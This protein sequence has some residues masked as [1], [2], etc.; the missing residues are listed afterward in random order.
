M[1][2]LEAIEQT[3]RTVYRETYEDF[4][5]WERDE[6]LLQHILRSLRRTK[7]APRQQWTDVASE[8]QESFLNRQE[9]CSIVTY[10]W[11]DD[12]AHVHTTEHTVG[13]TKASSNFKKLKGVPRFLNCSPVSRSMTRDVGTGAL[14]AP[15]ADSKKFSIGAYL[16]EFPYLDWVDNLDDSDRIYGLTVTH[17]VL[18]M[19]Y[20]RE[21]CPP[22]LEIKLIF[23]K[24]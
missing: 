21:I 5:S 12:G 2:D 18:P 6:S 16:K 22:S 23:F 13:L 4:Y 24:R 11:S 1:E 17:T 19:G 20:P 8:P 7:T 10:Q 14:F 9:S 15:F 3:G